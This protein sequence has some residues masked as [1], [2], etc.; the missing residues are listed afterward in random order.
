MSTT[1][2]YS[3]VRKYEH[4]TLGD[5]QKR[6]DRD[7][8]AFT[9]GAQNALDRLLSALSSTM[10]LRAYGDFIEDAA[11]DILSDIQRGKLA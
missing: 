5:S 7:A 2:T 6:Y 1:Y 4:A 10:T 11:A 9:A 8:D 3:Q